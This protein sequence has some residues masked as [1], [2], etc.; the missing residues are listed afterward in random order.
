MSAAKLWLV[1]VP[2][3]VI[4]Y[5]SSVYDADDSGRTRIDLVND[6]EVLDR[7]GEILDDMKDHEPWQVAVEVFRRVPTTILRIDDPTF[8][9]DYFARRGQYAS[10][11]LRSALALGDDEVAYR[12]VDASGCPEAARAKDYEAFLPLKVANPFDPA[13]MPGRVRPVRQDDGSSRDE[14]VVEP[15]FDPGVPAPMQ[16]YFKPG[17]EPPAPLFRPMGMPAWTFATED[18]ADRVSRAGITGIAFQEIEGD[19]AARETIQRRQPQ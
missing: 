8:D 9:L 6:A 14:W 13:R 15:P 16:V 7:R 5:L 1:T 3:S 18:L 19:R 10:S 12:P 2:V 11:R 17:F 4:A